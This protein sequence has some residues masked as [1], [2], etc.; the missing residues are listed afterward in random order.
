MA[1]DLLVP[2]STEVIEENPDC[3]LGGGDKD[4]TLG[5]KIDVRN[6]DYHQQLGIPREP[7]LPWGKEY[8]VTVQELSGLSWPLR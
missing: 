7:E 2:V 8:P 4:G 5:I 1:L 6:Q 3:I